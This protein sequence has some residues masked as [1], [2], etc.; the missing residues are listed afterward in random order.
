ML[1]GFSALKRTVRMHAE[2][3]ASAERPGG[4]TGIEA[5]RP[6]PHDPLD[7]L[8]L[9]SAVDYNSIR[10]TRMLHADAH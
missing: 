4:F 2:S 9:G 1:L 8:E 5:S 7:R 3:L 10:A 6:R